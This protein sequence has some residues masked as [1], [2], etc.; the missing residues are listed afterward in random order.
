MNSTRARRPL[1]S[2]VALVAHG[3]YG[4]GDVAPFSDVDIML[5]HSPRISERIGGLADRLLRDVF[6][7][8]LIMGHSVRTPEQ[9]WRLARDIPTIAT[10]L[11]ESRLMAGDARLFEQFETLFRR[12]VR[13]RIRLLLTAIHKERQQERLR[14]GETVFLL[15]PNIKRSRGGLRDIQ[16]VRWLGARATGEPRRATSNN[17]GAVG[18]RPRH[19]RTGQRVPALAAQRTAFCRG[20]GQRRPQ[21]R[22][23]VAHRRAP[24][25]SARR[26]PVARRAVH[27]R[28][29]PAHAGRQ[30]H[31]RCAS[32]PRCWPA[33]ASTA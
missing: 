19:A 8:G 21:P 10:S 4:R 31:C 11:M 18:R 24:R 1:R 20:P 5:L 12:S 3:G 23:A 32:R 28:V 26:R 27:A 2:H 7:A 16:F 6:D 29:F 9:A 22:R 30:P 14:Y 13:G 15:E 25:L 17:S 33:R